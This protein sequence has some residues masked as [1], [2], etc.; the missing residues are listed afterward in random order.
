MITTA[1]VLTLAEVFARQPAGFL[2]KDLR[3]EAVG[4][5]GQR[6]TPRFVRTMAMGTLPLWTQR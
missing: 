3:A 4:D 2:P 6:P 5:H 1:G